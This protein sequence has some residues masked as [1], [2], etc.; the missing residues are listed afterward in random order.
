MVWYTFLDFTVRGRLKSKRKNFRFFEFLS[1]KPYFEQ[2]NNYRDLCR[3]IFK[4]KDLFQ[5]NKS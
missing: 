3:V 2:K 5:G 4:V 1:S